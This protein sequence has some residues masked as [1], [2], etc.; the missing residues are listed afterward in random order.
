MKLNIGDVVRL[1]VPVLGNKINDIGVVFNTYAD[2]SGN[3]IAAQVIF[4]NGE[5]DG[6]SVNDQIRFLNKESITVKTEKIINYKFS[7]A[8]QVSRDYNNGFWDEILK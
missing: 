7:N 2:F 1:K 4:S 6:F 8:M 5:Y 3:G